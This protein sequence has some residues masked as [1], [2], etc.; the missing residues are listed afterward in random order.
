MTGIR[1]QGNLGDDRGG[2][3][4][5]RRKAPRL[6]LGLGVSGL[7]ATV[8]AHFRNLGWDVARAPSGEEAGRLASRHKATAVVLPVESNTES[9]L[10]TCAKL[11]LV[12]PHARVVLLG[13]EDRRLAKYARYAGAVGYLPAGAG[14]AAIVRAVLG[15]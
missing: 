3:C 6:V 5:P 15:N 14:V 4:C 11:S 12:R 1:T 2:L 10:L 13:P 7:A 8:D 9:G